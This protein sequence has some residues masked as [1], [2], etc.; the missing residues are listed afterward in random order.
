MAQVMQ[1]GA[2][3]A[4]SFSN[5][6]IYLT[7]LRIADSPGSLPVS[8]PATHLLTP[9][10][11]LS[12]RSPSLSMPLSQRSP[13]LPNMNMWSA[14]GVQAEASTIMLTQSMDV[15]HSSVKIPLARNSL[16]PYY[17]N[18][19]PR[20]RRSSNELTRAFC[21]TEPTCERR[22]EAWRSLQHHLRVKHGIVRKRYEDD[23]SFDQSV[24]HGATY[25]EKTWAD[26]ANT[27][28]S[29]VLHHQQSPPRPAQHTTQYF[30]AEPI[31]PPFIGATLHTSK[32][33]PIGP[34]T[35]NVTLHP[36]HLSSPGGMMSEVLLPTYGHLSSP[37][38]GHSPCNPYSPEPPSLPLPSAHDLELL[39]DDFIEQNQAWAV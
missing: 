21:C 3:L 33:G 28:S 24:I 27:A 22:Y 32:S 25:E 13:S 39:L 29:P 37:M 15:G 5:D 11:P 26:S 20:C 10:M 30:K 16:P 35:A 38:S 8:P 14:M 2:M 18:K 6:L 9:S 36:A 31:T 12:Q 7:Q 17:L 34:A 4:S 19:T 23:P 1:P